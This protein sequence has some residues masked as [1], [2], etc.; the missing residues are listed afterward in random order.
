MSGEDLNDLTSASSMYQSILNKDEKSLT[1]KDSKMKEM[2]KLQIDTTLN[3]IE[4]LASRTN[5]YNMIN[6]KSESNLKKD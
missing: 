1:M 2:L 4:A 6:I 5:A 3:K